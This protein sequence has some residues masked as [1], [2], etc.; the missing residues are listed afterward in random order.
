MR[1]VSESQYI[2]DCLGRRLI[3]F[4]G[5]GG[6]GKSSLAWSTAVACSRKGLK[7]GVAAWKS[8]QTFPPP[9]NIDLIELETLAAF[10]EYVVKVVRF[11]KVY[12]VVFD[13]P[14][15]S[16]FVAAAPGLSDT[17]IG[18]KLWDLWDNKTYDLLVVDLPASGHAYQF[19]QS[20]L[21]VKKYF[22]WV[23][24]TGTC[25]GSWKCSG[26]LR[27]AWIW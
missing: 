22:P 15:L 27:S 16:T 19:F 25:S 17:V 24:S 12:D 20:P 3:F 7:V 1:S 23:W 21:G 2:Q 11:E 10:R 5:K 18:G 9:P 4:T 6:V 13:N 26:T 14:V 8:V